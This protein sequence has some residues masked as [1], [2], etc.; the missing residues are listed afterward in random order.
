MKQVV[1][2][3][4]RGQIVVIDCPIPQLDD[5]KVLVRVH[6]SVLSSGTERAKLVLGEKSLLGKARSRPQDVA[7]VRETLRREGVRRT[8]EKVQDRLHTLQPLGYSAA[9]VIVGV[10]SKIDALRVGTRVAISGAGVANHAEYNAVPSQLCAP[11]PDSVAFDDGAFVTLG[12]IALQG[13]RQADVRPGEAC[14]VIGLGLIGQLTARLLNA[15][16]SPSVGIDPKRAARELAAGALVNA[17]SELDDSVGAHFDHVIVTASS[18]DPTLLR[19]AARHLRDRGTITVVGDVPLV[20]D[21]NEFFNGEFDLRISRSYGPGR[22][23]PLYEDLGVDYPI[24]YVRW[25]EGRNFAEVV[26]LLA[27]GRLEVASLVDQR[28]PVDEAPAAYELLKTQ[29]GPHAI[30][31]TYP[32]AEAE[33]GVATVTRE[34]VRSPAKSGKLGSG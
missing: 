4:A 25:T 14:L 31:L 19:R 2:N 3:Q 7:V 16:G 8:F 15:Y 26:R 32:T 6:S 5:H 11:L 34:P 28:F 17:L 1:Q 18:A 27:A 30:A 24:G 13:I 9:G 29:G 21:R 23:D 22:Y 10:G 20:L 33:T 12:S